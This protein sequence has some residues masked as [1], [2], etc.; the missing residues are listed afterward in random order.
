GSGQP[1]SHRPTSCRRA[2]CS[3]PEPPCVADA[4][5][6]RCRCSTRTCIYVPLGSAAGGGGACRRPPI[7]LPCSPLALVLVLRDVRLRAE[8]VSHVLQGGLDLDHLHSQRSNAGLGLVGGL[9][10]ASDP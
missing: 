4:C 3:L 10:G 8:G 5:G 7:R 2:S 9:Q 6:C 1:A